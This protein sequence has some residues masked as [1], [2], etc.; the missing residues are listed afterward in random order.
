MTS[1]SGPVAGHYLAKSLGAPFKVYL[2]NGVTTETDPVSGKII[3]SITDL[4]GLLAAV[5]QSRVSHP[6]KLSGADLK[7]IRSALRLKSGM[8]ASALDCTPEHYSRCETGQKTMSTTTEKLFRG[9]AFVIALL[10]NRSLRDSLRE[11]Q[12]SKTIA[13]QDTKEGLEAIGKLFSDLKITPVFSANDELCFTFSR[14]CPESDT[15]CGDD[16]AKWKNDIE[17]IVA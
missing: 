7:F 8:L 5:V 13:H 1:P 4:S 11:N 15:P 14:R 3:T 16:D 10:N 6:R 12:K 17:P 9:F 2:A